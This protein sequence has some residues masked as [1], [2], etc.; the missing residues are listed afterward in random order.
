M[1]HG[2]N[3]LA[4]HRNGKNQQKSHGPAMAFRAEPRC[5]SSTAFLDRAFLRSVHRLLRGGLNGGLAG[6]RAHF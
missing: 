2:R 4:S 3:A 1:L 6:Q 5:P